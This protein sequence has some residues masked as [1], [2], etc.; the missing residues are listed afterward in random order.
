MMSSQTLGVSIYGYMLCKLKLEDVGIF[1]LFYFQYK[2]KLV[3]GEGPR[4]NVFKISD[5]NLVTY[6]NEPHKSE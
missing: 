2:L 5:N 6:L 3:F 1:I 4:H